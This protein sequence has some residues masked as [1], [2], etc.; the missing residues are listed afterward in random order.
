MADPGKAQRRS[1]REQPPEGATAGVAVQN[2]RFLSA[3]R[4][5]AEVTAHRIHLCTAEDVRWTA[6]IPS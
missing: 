6:A 2:D 3:Q 1:E 5:R 4:Q